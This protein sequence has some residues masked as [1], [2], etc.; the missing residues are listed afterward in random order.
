MAVSTVAKM[1]TFPGNAQKEVEGEV[2]VEAEG[3]EAS[4]QSIFARKLLL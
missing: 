3:V 1:V 2:E 4:V